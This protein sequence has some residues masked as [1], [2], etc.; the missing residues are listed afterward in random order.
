MQNYLSTLDYL[1]EKTVKSS[2]K[3]NSKY[4]PKLRHKL[5]KANVYSVFWLTKYTIQDENLFS[6]S[7]IHNY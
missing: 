2:L 3:Y 7:H 6:Y 1:I 5:G 4:K